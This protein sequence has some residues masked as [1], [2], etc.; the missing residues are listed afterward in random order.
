MLY[1]LRKPVA[2]TGERQVYGNRINVHFNDSTA[3]WAELPESGML[4]EH[5]EEDFYQQLTGT[6][7]MAYFSNQEL[8]RLDVEGNVVAILLP[9][10][11]DSSYNKLVNA[12][13]SYLTLEMTGKEIKHLKMWPEV[14]GTVT[15]LFDIKQSQKYI[16]GFKWLESLR[17]K[18]SWYGNQLKWIDELGDVP[19]DLDAYFREPPLFKVLTPPKRQLQ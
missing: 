11:K 18:R 3:D 10:E 17:P 2:W 13:S 4:A 14:S 16:S 5:V 8:D 12:E 9:Q 7:M 6:H 15:P 1:M 19:D